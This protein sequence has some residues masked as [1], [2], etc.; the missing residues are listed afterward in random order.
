VDDVGVGCAKVQ[1]DD[2]ETS[3]FVA[4][5]PALS[6]FDKVGSRKSLSLNVGFSNKIE[7]IYHRYHRQT[8]RNTAAADAEAG[9]SDKDTA[10]P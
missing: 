2:N 8:P 10:E 1:F 7:I 6:I 3:Y 9:T 4:E 5:C